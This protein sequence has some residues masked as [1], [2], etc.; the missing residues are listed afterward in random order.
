M[1]NSASL[2]RTASARWMRTGVK[3]I[4]P[5]LA[6]TSNHSVGPMAFVML[7]GRVRWLLAVIFASPESSRC[8]E[9]ILL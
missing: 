4:R 1:L 5:S 6:S 9:E 7:L 3:M 2:A 8:G